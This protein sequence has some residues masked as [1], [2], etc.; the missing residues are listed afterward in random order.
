[1][2]CFNKDASLAVEIINLFQS[3]FSN[4]YKP[5]LLNNYNINTINKTDNSLFCR[6]L[7]NIFKMVVF[8]KFRFISLSQSLGP[9]GISVKKKVTE[10]FTLNSSSF[11]DKNV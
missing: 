11:L 1:M 5:N 3:N 4:I 6:N 10:R 8:N 9:D 2:T 7:V